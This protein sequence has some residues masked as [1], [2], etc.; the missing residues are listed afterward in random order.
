MI[1]SSESKEPGQQ[2]EN[3]S[4]PAADDPQKPSPLRS[5]FSNTFPEIIR[6]LGV[7]IVVSTYQAGYLIILRAEEG[8]GLNTHFRIFPRPM[9]MVANQGRMALGV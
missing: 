6:Q 3:E 2:A 8:G 1:D 4:N 7:S 9:G 5:V